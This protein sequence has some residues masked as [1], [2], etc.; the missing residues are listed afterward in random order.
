MK[1]KR[2]RLVHMPL[3]SFFSKRL[4]RDVGYNWKGAN[5][6]YLFLLIAICCVPATLKVRERMLGSLQTS[7]TEILNQ[8]PDIHIE[9]GQAAIPQQQPYFINRANGT[10]LAIID[11]TGSMNYIDDPKVMLLLTET[12][13]IL[14]RGKNLFNTFDL[15]GIAD[16]EINKVILNRW[17]QTAKDSIAPLSYGIFLM[18]SYIFAV[19]VLLFFAI[20]GLILAHLFNNP[21]GFAGSL[22]IATVAATPAIIFITIS[23]ALGQAIPGLAYLAITLIY[24]FVGIKACSKIPETDEKI[25]LK[26]FLHEE[27]GLIEEAA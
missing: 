2:Y 18:L 6:A 15:A 4:Y 10:P 8:I 9:E 21:L 26:S 7:H 16:L 1:N 20:I 13:L 24:L 22:R 19:M 11:T 5:F 3:L 14:R 23:A 17:F 27:E 25:D 12:K